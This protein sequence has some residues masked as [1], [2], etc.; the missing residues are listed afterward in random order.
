MLGCMQAAANPARGRT[1]RGGVDRRLLG[2]TSGARGYLIVTVVFGLAGT[3]LILAQAGL[4]AHALAAAARGVVAAALAG[5]L[6]VLLAVVAARAA[7]SYAGDVTALRAAAT[8]KSGLRR[9]LTARSLQLG[10][11]WLGGQRAG[12]I[13]TLSTRGL[14]GLDSYFARY[15]PQLVLAV[16]VPIAVLVRVAVADWVSAVVIAVTLPLIPAFAVLVGWHTK[17]QTRR[18]WRLLATLGGHFLD[19]VEGLPTLKLFGRARAQEGVIAKVTNDYRAATMSTLRV[20]FLSG[21]VLELAAALATALVAV[22]VGLRLLYGHLGYETAMLV[23]LLTP[24]AYLPLR[25]VGSQFHASMEGAAAATRVFEIL[26]TPV[27]GPPPPSPRTKLRAARADLRSEDIRLNRVTVAYP[28]RPRPALEGVSLT[29]APGERIVLRGPSGAGKSTLI[30]LLLRFIA[31]AAGSIAVGDRDLA[32][33]DMGLWRRQIGW[34]PQQPYLFGGTAADN[35]ALGKAGASRDAICRAARLAGAADFIEALPAGY[36][37]PLGE[38]GLRLSAGQRQ[39]IALARVFLRDPPLLLLDEPAAHLDPVSARQI[40][41]ALDTALAD[42]TVILVSHGQGWDGGG[43]RSIR[44]GHGK[45]MPPARAACP[46]GPNAAA[47]HR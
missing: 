39:R 16:L 3:G 25:A 10:P 21:L 41:T 23:L 44:L 1:G 27:P 36:D 9:A 17:A 35:I 26:D 43:C 24:E 30:A 8:V 11:V 4:L 38:R 14:D 20:A 19:V 29:I 5:T 15:L 40:G 7:V 22:E 13:T 46:V 32:A 47:V 18:Q 31:P 37:T 28:G 33:L 42:R 12:E 45:L 6:A 2:Y 34:V